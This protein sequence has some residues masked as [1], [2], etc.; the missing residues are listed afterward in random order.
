MPFG[1]QPNRQGSPS[2]QPLQPA[3]E[4]SGLIELD[5][6]IDVTCGTPAKPE[7]DLQLLG[8]STLKRDVYI[9]HC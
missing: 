6:T 3:I 8:Q 2:K 1:P 5:A 7:G 9:F 4:A